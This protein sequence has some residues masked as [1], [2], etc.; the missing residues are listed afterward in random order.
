MS[1][2]L[3]NNVLM[4]NNEKIKETIVNLLKLFRRRGYFNTNN[5]DKV[6]KMVTDIKMNGKTNLT[7]D[8]VKISIYYKDI[9][10]KNIS[11]GS[12]V[13]EFLSK[14]TDFIKFVILKEFSKKVYKQVNDYKSSYIFHIFE[15]LED[16]PSKNIVPEHQLLSEEDK[17]ELKKVYDISLFPKIFDTD[18]MSRY[19]GAKVGDIFRIKRLNLNSG[20]STY[21]R[22][23]VKDSAISFL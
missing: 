13:D 12:E 8:K 10:L 2:V 9:D 16:I 19:Y 22:K 18:M 5:D 7:V 11:S 3:L 21:Y 23:V 15:M 20:I 6:V 17:E 1:Q 4:N 14:N